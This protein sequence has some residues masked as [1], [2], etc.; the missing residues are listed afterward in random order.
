VVAGAVVAGFLDAVGIVPAA[1]DDAG[2]GPLAALAQVPAGGDVGRHGGERL[3]AVVR[4][5]KPGQ[6][7]G[8][9]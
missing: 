8:G 3:L 9:G 5:K 1:L 2:A 7:P 6:R 4:G